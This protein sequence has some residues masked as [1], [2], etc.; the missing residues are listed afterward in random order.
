M[1]LKN[2]TRKILINK[3]LR[4]LGH[5]AID[6]G[7]LVPLGGRAPRINRALRI[8]RG[9]AGVGVGW[10]GNMGFSLWKFLVLLLGD[11]GV[12]GGSIPHFQPP[13]K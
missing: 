5:C 2:L 4:C 10:A 9:D 1:V 11:L 3:E 8:S 7:A 13:K 12:L 6:G